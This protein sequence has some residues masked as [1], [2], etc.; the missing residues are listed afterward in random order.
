MAGWKM[1]KYTG[2][3]AAA[4][5]A[6]G[7]CPGLAI[8][9]SSAESSVGPAPPVDTI[10]FA[11]GSWGHRPYQWVIRADG[12]GEVRNQA[13]GDTEFNDPVLLVR[14]FQADRAAFE[15]VRAL[16]RLAESYTIR[17]LQCRLVATDGPEAEMVWSFEG[18]GRQ[19]H[20]VYG[21]QSAEAAR[22]YQAIR[23]GDDAIWAR[24]DG[25]DGERHRGSELPSLN[26]ATIVPRS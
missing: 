1:V 14:R 22:V 13:P 24:V 18:R 5:F 23:D 6:L 9:Q 19:L 11:L 3:L 4:L 25:H 21:C 17:E 15:R 12:S 7:E 16:L 8:A 2:W 20:V 26:L 10:S